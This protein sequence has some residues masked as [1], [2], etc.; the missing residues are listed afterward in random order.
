MK[1]FLQLFRQD[2]TIRPVNKSC[3]ENKCLSLFRKFQ[4]LFR[5]FH[6]FCLI[7]KYVT[8]PLLTN[9][10]CSCYQSALGKTLL[11]PGRCRA[12]EAGENTHSTSS[13]LKGWAWHRGRS[14]YASSF[15]KVPVLLLYF[16]SPSLSIKHS[17]WINISHVGSETNGL[18]LY[19]RVLYYFQVPSPLISVWLLSFSYCSWIC[20]VPVNDQEWSV[21]SP[22]SAELQE[23]QNHLLHEPNIVFMK[24]TFKKNYG[25]PITLDRSEY[26]N[27]FHVKC[28]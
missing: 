27:T 28:S 11:L 22:S 3:W 16:A 14:G 19:T 9:T 20:I 1:Y 5:H 13:N 10:A 7:T 18:N 26:C 21:C 17:P 23:S 6:Q 12:K 25:N 15:L 2:A 24:S 4:Q 8:F